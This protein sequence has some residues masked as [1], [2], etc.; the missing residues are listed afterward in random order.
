M[1]LEPLKRLT[2]DL[3]KAA[4]TLSRAEARYLVDYYYQLQEFR[5]SSNNQIRSMA[6]T[7]EPHDVLDWLAQNT[8]TLEK[9][10]KSALDAYTSGDGVGRWSK[11]IVGIGPVIS[12]GLLAHIDIEKAPTAGHIWRFAGLDPTTTW[13]KK[14]KRPWNAQLKTLCWKIGESFVKVTNRKGDIYGHLTS[15]ATAC[16]CER[17]IFTTAR[18]ARE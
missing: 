5:K 4:V 10:I 13:E 15:Q 9:N 1:E 2:K 6:D 12:A 18:F 17:N 14:Q 16:Q 11:S 8:A 3:R 7:A